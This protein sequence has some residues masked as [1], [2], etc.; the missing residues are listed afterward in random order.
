MSFTRYIKSNKIIDEKDFL[1]AAKKIKSFSSSSG[2]KYVVTDV[3]GD[4]ISFKRLNSKNPDEDWPLD[5]KRVFEAF[6]NL[7]DFRTENFMKYVP[8]RH[9][10]ARGLLI[11]LG[12]LIQQ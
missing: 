12:L 9:S 1:Q 7:N 11:H 4:V 5:L 3:K 6:Q 10:P 2:K 8:I